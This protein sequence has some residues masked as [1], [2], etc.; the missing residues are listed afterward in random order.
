MSRIIGDAVAFVVKTG[1]RFGRRQG[2]CCEDND[3]DKNQEAK[4]IKGRIAYSPFYDGLA[5]GASHR[6]LVFS[7]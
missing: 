7:S 3:K 5:E 2:G 6:G 4:G 1:R